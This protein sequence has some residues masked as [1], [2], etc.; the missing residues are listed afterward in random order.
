[1]KKT[2]LAAMIALTGSMAFNNADAAPIYS[3]S[4]TNYTAG[5]IFLGF[6][7]SGG[8]GAANSYLLNLGDFG[9]FPILK[10]GD[11]PVE[12]FDV[13]SSLATV[14]GSDWYTRSQVTWGIFGMTPST[15]FPV[16]SSTS[17]DRASAPITRTFNQLATSY[18]SYT[19][20]GGNYNSAI[21]NGPSTGSTTGVLG[22]GVVTGVLTPTWAFNIAKPSDFD[23]YAN[24]LEAGVAT[25]LEFYS[26]TA[27]SSDRITQFG[28]SSA[29]VISVVPEPSTYALFGFGALLLIVAYRRKANA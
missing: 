18:S 6:R 8:T 12:L 9:T 25:G 11:T 17:D 24:T 2:I 13:G 10:A 21:A 27:T 3:G 14:F 28:I 16:Y 29:G 7:A 20:M 15:R 4:P 22:S 23:V 5:N 19:G 1:M 26:T